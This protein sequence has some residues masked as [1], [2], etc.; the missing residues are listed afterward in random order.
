MASNFL[1]LRGL[2]RGESLKTAHLFPVIPPLF[3]LWAGKK[4]RS[5]LFSMKE[6]NVSVISKISIALLPCCLGCG[7]LSVPP[8]AQ[9]F[10]C[11]LKQHSFQ[12]GSF[13]TFWYNLQN[14]L[15][16]F[17]TFILYV[18]IFYLNIFMCIINAWCLRRSEKSV[19]S[20]GTGATDVFEPPCGCWELN[21]GP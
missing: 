8:V 10:V 3:P 15:F 13:S 17:L 7:L 5:W 21:P 20:S 18:W 14:S 9:G 19:R 11:I 6:R 4:K 12:L 16:F 2:R 1:L